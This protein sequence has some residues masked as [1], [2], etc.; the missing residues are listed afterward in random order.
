MNSKL[1]KREPSAGEAALTRPQEPATSDASARPALTRDDSLGYLVNHLG[2]LL[3]RALRSRIER[4]GVVPGQ[5]GPLLVLYERDGLTQRELCAKVQIEQSTMAYTLQR[6]E[7]D[8]LVRRVPDPHDGRQSRVLL[9]ERALELRDHLL[10]A[11]REVNELAVA[12]LEPEETAAFLR[13]VTRVIGNLEPNGR[14]S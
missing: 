6:M 10:A 5:F 8:G 1:W 9:T 2:R 7:R 14:G 12:G 4:H 13:S 11:A 3:E